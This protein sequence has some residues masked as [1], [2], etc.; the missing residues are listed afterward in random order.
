MQYKKQFTAKHIV[1]AQR[2]CEIAKSLDLSKLNEEEKSNLLNIFNQFL[3]QFYLS[4]NKLGHTDIVEHKIKTTEEKSIN[5]KQYRYTY[6]HKEEIQ[7][8]VSN[9]LE[10]DI[11]EPSSSPFNSPL[12]IIPKKANSQGEVK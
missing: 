2:L 5:V 10:N 1:N 12:W 3:Y 11:I 4:A 8:Q 7:K 6:V 9:L